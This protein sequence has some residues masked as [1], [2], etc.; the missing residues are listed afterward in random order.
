MM[1]YYL[2]STVKK[3]DELVCDTFIT[4][5]IPFT[6][7]LSGG[8]APNLN[9]IVDIHFAT[10]ETALRAIDEVNPTN[11]FTW[12]RPDDFIQLAGNTP[13]SFYAIINV[14]NPAT[15]GVL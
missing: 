7:T 14:E 6:I 8:Y 2:K 4:K 11:S 3:R 12:T 15:W 5:Q 10:I 13:P 9:D 1:K